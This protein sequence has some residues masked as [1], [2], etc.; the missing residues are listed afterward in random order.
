M[1]YQYW[2]TPGS[3]MGLC[4]ISVGLRKAVGHNVHGAQANSFKGSSI[5]GPGKEDLSTVT[6]IFR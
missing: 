4:H 3:Y 2:M 1:P 6:F 5:G